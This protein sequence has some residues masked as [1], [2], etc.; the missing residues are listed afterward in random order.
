MS[1]DATTANISRKVKPSREIKVIMPPT[2]KSTKG[3]LNKRRALELFKRCSFKSL[4][5]MYRVVKKAA[6]PIHE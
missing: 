3:G 6:M 1:S 4:L 2:V 5:Q